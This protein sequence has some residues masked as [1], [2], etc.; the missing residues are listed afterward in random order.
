MV[1]IVETSL[2]TGGRYKRDE[3]GLRMA[4]FSCGASVGQFVGPLF[5]SGVFSMMDGKLG[6]AA[7]R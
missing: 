6:Y 2:L 1:S 3:L 5:A 7:W 4:Y